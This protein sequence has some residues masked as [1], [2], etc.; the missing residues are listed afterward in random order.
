MRALSR[1]A[2]ARLILA[3]DCGAFGFPGVGPG[4]GVALGEVG[5]DVADEVGH[6]S[7]AA[8]ADDILG[9]I[10]KETLD[11]VDPG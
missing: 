4:T 10:G 3:R 6:R 7:E 5:F 11:E 1:A 9:E 8:G 2:R